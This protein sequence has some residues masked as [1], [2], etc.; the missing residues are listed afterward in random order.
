M[1]ILAAHL[2][3]TKEKQITLHFNLHARSREAGRPAFLINMAA[4]IA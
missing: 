2:I 3:R 1:C 4:E